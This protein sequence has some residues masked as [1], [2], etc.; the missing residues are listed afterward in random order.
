MLAAF[1]S[2]GASLLHVG[3]LPQGLP[4][5]PHEVIVGAAGELCDVRDVVVNAPEPLCRVDCVNF[6]QVGL[7][8]SSCR[9]FA[10]LVYPERPG[11]V[12]GNSLTV[13][14][15]ESLDGG[16]AHVGRGEGTVIDILTHQPVSQTGR[17]W[18][19]GG[20]DPAKRLLSFDTNPQ[21]QRFL[22]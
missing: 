8:L 17:C 12:K 18:H 11:G 2:P 20:H 9:A 3:I 19:W 13:G 6:L 5:L 21:L 1:E 16:G 10:C 15:A 14:G 4:L 7:I 22:L